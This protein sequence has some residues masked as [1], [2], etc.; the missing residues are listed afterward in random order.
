MS[1]RM[2]SCN[3]CTFK[4]KHKFS[5]NRH[6]ESMHGGTSSTP[7]VMPEP[8]IID[9]SSIEVY[10]AI[11]VR[12]MLSSIQLEE[13]TNKFVSEGLDMEML[14][15]MQIADI[16][17]CLREIGINRFGDRQKICEKNCRRKEKI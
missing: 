2:F 1:T 9:Y 8:C 13:M 14:L 5:F 17:E 15:S 16:K 4:S 7:N 11:D 3:I 6:V 10:R 12:S